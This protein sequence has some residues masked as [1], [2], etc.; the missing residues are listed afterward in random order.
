MEEK[1]VLTGAV[2]PFW[3][4][5][6]QV[7]GSKQKRT[8][9][10]GLKVVSAMKIV[11]VRAQATAADGG[12]DRRLVGVEVLG[13]QLA[14]LLRAMGEAAAAL[15]ADRVPRPTEAKAK[16]KPDARGGHGGHGGWG[17]GGQGGTREGLGGGG[18]A[19]API[20]LE[21]E[22]RHYGGAAAGGAARVLSGQ[23]AAAHRAQHQGRP[24][25]PTAGRGVGPSL[26]ACTAAAAAEEEEEELQ[27]AIRAS[28]ADHA[29]SASA[30][31]PGRAACGTLSPSASRTNHA[32]A[33]TAANDADAGGMSADLKAR[34]REK[35][36]LRK[37]KWTVE[38]ELFT[39]AIIREFE[40][41][42]LA[43]PPG[44]TLRSHGGPR[45]NAT[46]G[47]AAPPRPERG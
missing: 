31:A 24:Q 23:A 25:Q 32:A 9:D 42:M 39:T 16:A 5:I 7:V 21:A 11:R 10:G 27:R 4:A 18:S 2:L 15:Q 34:L 35:A 20:D 19:S 37:G 12:G 38:E 47:V 41:G 29:V 26:F 44:T 1:H 17:G 28:L 6:S 30:S 40:R 3:A 8:R 13:A 45:G 22:A 14:R 46:T 33:A 36:P 43:C